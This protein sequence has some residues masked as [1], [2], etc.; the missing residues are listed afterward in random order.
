MPDNIITVKVLV[1]ATG[2][3]NQLPAYALDNSLLFGANQG[4][5]QIG[6]ISRAKADIIIT[7]METISQSFHPGF[8]I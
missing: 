3:V 6:S 7:P 1:Q 4:G 5:D 2:G 8:C